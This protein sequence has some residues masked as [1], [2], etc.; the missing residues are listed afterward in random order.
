MN[1]YESYDDYRWRMLISAVLTLPE[2]SERLAL[3]RLYRRA[4]LCRPF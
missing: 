1:L 4:G 3:E 2:V